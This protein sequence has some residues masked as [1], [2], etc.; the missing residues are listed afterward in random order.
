MN[1]VWVLVCDAARGRLLE[2]GEG[3]ASWHQVEAFAHEES[4][5]KASELVTDHSGRS[6]SEGGSVHHNALAPSSSPKEVEQRH[7]AHTLATAIDQA[8]RAK[9]F[10]KWV[11]VA[12][13]HFLG[14]LKKELTAEA[15]ASLLSTVDKDLT[16]L[17]LRDVA[18]QLHDAVRI[19]PDQR[20]VVREPR[21]H[22]H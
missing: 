6:S 16:H 10:K 5:S 1:T 20:E 4:R 17:E 7:F 11:L 9:R 14:M 21:K 8:A 22:G 18:T 15:A 2:V 12:P 19:P 3:D 13:P